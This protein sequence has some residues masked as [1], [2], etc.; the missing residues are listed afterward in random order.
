MSNVD[1]AGSGGSTGGS[2]NVVASSDASGDASSTKMIFP[3]KASANGRYLVDQNGVP[4]RIQG[5]AGWG[6]IANLVP[7]E[8]DTYL[9]DRQSRGFNTVIVNLLEHK[10]AVQAPRNRGGDF[11]F[12]AHANG[13]YDFSTTNPAY[14]SFADAA[15]DKMAA[16]GMLVLLDIMYLGNGGGDEGW[17]E[18]L[19]NA[20]NTPAKC[21]S[22]G[23]F[24][25]ARWKDRA[26]IVW[27]LSGDYTPPAGSDAE[28]RLLQIHKGIRDAGATQIAS[29][30]VFDKLSSDWPGFLPFL[31]INGVYASGPPIYQSARTAFGRPKP[32]PV[33]L[34]ESGYEQ[35]GWFPGDPASIRSYLWWAQLSAVGGALY[36][37]RDVWAFSTD[38]WNTGYP[39]G[40]QR[41]QLSL[42]TPGS[43]A[44][45]HMA[46]LLRSLSWFDLVPSG[47]AGMKA[48]VT[49]GAGT[50]GNADYVAAAASADGKSL[51][52]Y[53]PPSGAANRTITVDM[54]AMS[55]PSTARWWDPAS[56]A[57]SA[58]ASNLGNTGT[59]AFTVAGNNA[60]G[61]HDWV[62]VLASP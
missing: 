8:M 22:Y 24:L 21:Y 54:S 48:L 50:M 41:W 57:F 1:G 7:G 47:L 38:S 14:F 42:D 36:G 58:I 28:A 40:A 49:D 33:F 16:A 12:T 17:F 18:E 15:L 2:A 6:F 31:Q 26:N 61:A 30:H 37:H 20:T 9:A 11:P 3:L 35:E 56:G 27:I 23:Q 44:V 4:F 60:A 29:V 5:D 34:I 43:Q 19:T 52:A 53:L 46:D 10:F 62:L 39:F 59:H 51:V 45:K 32:I 55:G 13:S 25:G